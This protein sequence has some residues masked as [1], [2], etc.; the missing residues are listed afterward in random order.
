MDHTDNTE[1]SLLEKL[2]QVCVQRQLLQTADA[3]SSTRPLI[4]ILPTLVKGLGF[5]RMPELK[6]S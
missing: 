1:S 3:I 4:R 6:Q 5:F 2:K